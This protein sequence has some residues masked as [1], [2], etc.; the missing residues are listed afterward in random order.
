MASKDKVASAH[1]IY[2]RRYLA[3]FILLLITSTLVVSC[4]RTDNTTP[5]ITYAMPITVAAIPSYVALEKGFWKEEGLDVQAQMFSSGRQALDA[6]LAKN[7]EVM[8][9]SE[10]PLMHAI[11]QGNQIYIVTTVTQHQEVKLIARRD[12]G[13]QSAKDLKAKRIATLPGTNS[14]Y[15][16]YEFLRKNN[17]SIEDVDITNMNPPDMVTALVQGN[18]D[19]YFAWE[20]H[21]YYAQKQLS[22]NAII[23]P[24]G[25]L[26][27]G[28]HCVAMNQEFV[29]ANPDVVEKLIRGF[30]RAETFVNEKP[31]E[32]MAIVSKITASN[33]RSGRTLGSHRCEV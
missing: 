33:T 18:I 6:L 21:I 31:D 23:F 26:Y 17:I 28:R 27:H 1:K 16:M 5:K 10:T 32:S 20:P 19:A 30:R 2:F 22:Q 8:S 11:L 9:V 29:R 3:L 24:P 7:A 25:D 12:K 14:D 15:F 4:L 13:I